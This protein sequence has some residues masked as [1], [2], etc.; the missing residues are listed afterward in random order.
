MSAEHH[1]SIIHERINTDLSS[2][3]MSTDICHTIVDTLAQ[4][5]SGGDTRL[6]KQNI[7]QIAAQAALNHNQR[8]MGADILDAVRYLSAEIDVLDSHFEILDES[9]AAHPVANAM[10]AE[11]RKSGTLHHPVTGEPVKD[12]QAQVQL[13]FTAARSFTQM[14]D[15]ESELSA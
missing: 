14:F 6:S 2:N 11:L 12:I 4:M 13:I 3:P 15:Q 5:A 8:A 1:L 10:M 9:G 7:E